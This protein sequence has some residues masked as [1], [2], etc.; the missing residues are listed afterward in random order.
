VAIHA[1]EVARQQNSGGA[2]GSS[3]EAMVGEVDSEVER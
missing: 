3:E 1:E 2:R